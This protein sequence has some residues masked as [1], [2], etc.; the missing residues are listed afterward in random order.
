MRKQISKWLI[1]ILG[2]IFIMPVL[3]TF[4]NSFMRPEEISYRYGEGSPLLTLIPSRVT[5]YQY[6][7][8]LVER[9]EYLGMFWRSIQLSLIIV[10]GQVIYSILVGSILG[11]LKYRWCNL[12]KA[13]YI[14]AMFMPYQVLMLPSYIEMK[15][16]GLLGSDLSI[17]L[18]AIFSPIGV[19]FLMVIVGNISDEVIEAVQL[20]SSRWFTILRIAILPQIKGIITVLGI[21]TFSEV[22]NMVEQPIAMFEAASKYPLSVQLAYMKEDQMIIFACCMVYMIPV[23]LISFYFQESLDEELSSIKW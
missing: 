2:V 15:K 9:F 7:V 23:I 13:V 8:L 12:I 5:L 19:V 21:F 14:M 3:I 18:P 22:W 10:G 6:Y 1:L 17:I 4:T 11:R 16:I 20:E